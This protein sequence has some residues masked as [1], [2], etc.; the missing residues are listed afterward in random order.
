MTENDTQVPAPGPFAV[1]IRRSR[2]DRMIAGVASGVA[3]HFGVDV[4]LVRVAIAVLAIAG[5]IGVP[6][7]IAAW[8]L[9]PEEGHDHSIAD[10]VLEDL[11][12][13]H[14]HGWVG[15]TDAS[16]AGTYR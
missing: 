3:H 1:P 12:G 2:S 14:A 7:Y 6:L 4:T 15:P 9:L 16:G 10:E 11:R 8:L 13:R 5:G